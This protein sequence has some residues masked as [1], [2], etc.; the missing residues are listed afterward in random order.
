MST[1][2]RN[3][4]KLI[5]SL[6]MAF[7]SPVAVGVVMLILLLFFDTLWFFVLA[8]ALVC[9]TFLFMVYSAIW[10]ENIRFEITSNGILCYYCGKKLIQRFDLKDCSMGYHHLKD[11]NGGTE[12]LRLRITDKDGKNEIIDCEPIGE[13]EFYVMFEEMQSYSKIAPERLN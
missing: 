5:K 10:S 2:K 9:G 4:R 6:L 13:R 11:A 7:L 8:V 1:Y 3:P 12:N